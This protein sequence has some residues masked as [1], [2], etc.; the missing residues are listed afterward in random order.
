MS[1]YT[2]D[3]WVILEVDTGVEKF[4][5]AL[6]GWCGGYLHGDSWRLSSAIDEMIETETGYTFTTE[7]GSEYELKNSAYGMS[8][9]TGSIYSHM[10]E[11]VENTCV[12]IHILEDYDPR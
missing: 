11:E 8:G 4:K 1:A 7:S 6:S 3:R 5:R 2:P 10:L 9:L 12:K